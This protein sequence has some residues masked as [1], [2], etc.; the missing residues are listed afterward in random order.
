MPTSPEA[1]IAPSK[2]RLDVLKV[3]LQGQ[4]AFAPLRSCEPKR[5]RDKN[6]TGVAHVVWR[7]VFT[8]LV[9]ATV[10]PMGPIGRSLAG[11]WVGLF[12]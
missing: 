10:T 1:D 9:R 8:A 11:W 4:E 7:C 12:P 6:K 3:I 2:A 5:R